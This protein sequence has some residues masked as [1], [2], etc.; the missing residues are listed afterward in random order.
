MSNRPIITR[1]APSPTG[2]LHVGGARTAIFSYLLARR[3]NGK[4]I[5]RIEDTDVERSKKEFESE[6]LDSMKWLGLDWDA[7]PIYQSQRFDVYRSYIQKM[8]KAGTAYKCWATPE[9]LAAMREKATA[10]GKKPMYDRRY[11]NFTGTEPSGSFVV[12]FKTPLDGETILKDLVKGDICFQ[13]QEIDDFIILRSDNTPTYNFT[14]VIDDYEMKIS[15]VI[16]GDDHV[17]NTPK[18]ILMMQALG[19]DLPEFAH[20]PMILGPDK[21]KLS[22]R[23]GAVAVSQYREQGYL[24]TAM[25]NALLRLGWSHGDQ[26]FFSKD[27]MISLFD[28]SGCGKS[29]SV[30]DVAKLDHLNNQHMKAMDREE[31]VNLLRNNYGTDLS[32]L[33]NGDASIKLF[34]ALVERAVRLTD[35]KDLSAWYFE[36]SFV[37]DQKTIDSNVSACPAAALEALKVQWQGCADFTGENAFACIKTVATEQALKIPVIAKAVRVLLTGTLASPDMGIVLAA[38]GKDRAVERLSI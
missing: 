4:F 29:P 36:E 7:D 1:F 31:L 13:N 17:N 18:Q 35:F 21:A 6:I 23:H 12:R 26:E 11:R 16:R 9:E 3:H 27:Q 28:L 10:H 15:H 22:K 5:L 33:L 30:F 32:T 19:F 37:R 24:P 38:L 20:V 14:V 8:L 34:D 25:L 2:M